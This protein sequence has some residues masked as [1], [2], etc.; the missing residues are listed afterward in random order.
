MIDNQVR[1]SYGSMDASALGVSPSMRQK[2]RTAQSPTPT[3]PLATQGPGF[4]TYVTA[5][6]TLLAAQEA[7]DTTK[8]RRDGHSQ[9]QSNSQANSQ[10][11]A[12]E[13]D[14]SQAQ[15]ATEQELTDE[16]KQRVQE[17]K[18]IDREVRA[19]ERAQPRPFFAS[20]VGGQTSMA[21]R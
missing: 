1:T 4:S 12:Q 8:V 16:E 5:P 9:S 7:R 6:T 13:Q 14:Q 21:K 15:S 2:A 3:A 11:L 19:H 17:L 18:K 20:A 10:A